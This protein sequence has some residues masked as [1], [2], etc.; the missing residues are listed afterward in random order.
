ML[1]LY[2]DTQKTVV[3]V[4]IRIVNCLYGTN[5]KMIGIM[6]LYM[7]LICC[8]ARNVNLILT[9]TSFGQIMFIYLTFPVTYMVLFIYSHSDVI[10]AKQHV[11]LIH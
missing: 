5:I 1:R 10:I 7:V 3:F 8:L 6:T 9:N 4:M 2:H 11:V